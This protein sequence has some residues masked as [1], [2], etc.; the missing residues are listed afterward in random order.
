M[1]QLGEIIS[2]EDKHILFYTEAD[3]LRDKETAYLLIYHQ[4]KHKTKSFMQEESSCF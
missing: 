4:L 1:A 3:D 2:E